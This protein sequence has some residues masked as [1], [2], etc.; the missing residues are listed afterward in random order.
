MATMP[1]EGAEIGEGAA[2][3]A[4]VSSAL[5]FETEAGKVVRLWLRQS[6]GPATLLAD[7]T[8]TPAD[9]SVTT[10]KV[11]AA[12]IDGAAG[13]PSMRSLSTDAT[14]GGGAASDTVVSS[15][16]AVKAFVEALAG[17]INAFIYK[18]VK[19]CSANPKY[20][21]AN[22]GETYVVSV[23]GKIGGSSGPNV[24][25]GDLLLC[26]TDGA[27]EGT[28]A[29][30]GSKWN[31]IQANLDGAVTGPTSA[32]DGNIPLYNGTTGKIIKDGLLPDTDASLGAA[33]NTRV[34]TQKAVHDFVE[35][36]AGLL[37]AKALGTAKGD[38]IA[39]E[40]S[41][42][43]VRHA[44]GANGN[45]LG[46]DSAQ[47]DGLASL[48]KAQI[49]GLA[50]YRTSSGQFLHVMH[51]VRSSVQQ[52]TGQKSA[53]FLLP[54]DV[55]VETEFDR[56]ACFVGTKGEGSG[57]VARMG[58]YEDDGTGGKPVGAPLLDAGTVSLEAA[59]ERSIEISKK[60]PV[61]R[62]WLAYVM[63]GAS[64]TVGPFITLC[65]PIGAVAST[66]LETGLFGSWKQLEVA[67]VLPT[68]GTLSAATTN[69]L[70]G[71]RTK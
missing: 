43:P 17:A 47:S 12:N 51:G 15:Q 50:P 10:I 2:P 13:T 68:I 40:A 48:K 36:Q 24:E 30:V 42:K 32:V 59:G 28:Q 26:N 45:L 4:L 34:P 19:S 1:L 22:A 44:A 69:P 25:V 67:G 6:S 37:V 5:Y 55:A 29:E 35:T 53:M 41:G 7:L 9:G 23:A 38:T 61:G 31:I 8:G 63:Q 52:N 33:S 54:V 56:I 18:G 21:A 46:F 66:N 57:M 65:N 16:K 11:A 49:T 20:P 70:I 60:L 71:L 62:Y 64:V 14:L 39:Y 3:E 27:A 58:C